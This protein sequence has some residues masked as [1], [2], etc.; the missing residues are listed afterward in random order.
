MTTLYHFWSDAPS[1]R[2]RLALGCKGVDYRD[3]P[4]AY[5]DDETFF[6][7]GVAR[8]V[9]VLQL[10]DGGL[11]LDSTDIL[12]RIDSLFSGDP[13]LAEAR[14]DAAAWR[15]LLDWRKRVDAVLERLYA[16]VR[17]A[18]RNIGADEATLAAYKAEVQHRL[19]MSVEELANDRYAGYAQLDSLTNLKKLGRHLAERS[20]YMGEISIADMVLTADLFPLQAL[21]GIALPIDLMY[22]LDR[23]ERSCGVSLREGYLT[24]I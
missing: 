4:V 18:F 22:Y 24:D 9:P 8:Q 1:Q 15:A 23:V 16:P 14:V 20:F 11:L 19:G 12:W 2:V 5:D 10:D 17:P 13:P 7:L 3:V 21:D 6:D